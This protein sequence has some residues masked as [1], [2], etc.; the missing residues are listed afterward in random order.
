MTIV[1]NIR[2]RKNCLKMENVSHFVAFL[3][4]VNQLDGQMG[5][6][7]AWHWLIVKILLFSKLQSLE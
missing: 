2:M 7:L 4:L 1:E 6:F 3:T 5:N